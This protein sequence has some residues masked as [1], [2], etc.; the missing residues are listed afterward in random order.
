MNDLITP[1]HPD[2]AIFWTETTLSR[3]PSRNNPAINCVAPKEQAWVSTPDL[4]VDQQNLFYFY[5]LIG[6]LAAAKEALAEI[7]S[8]AESR[9]TASF[10]EALNHNLSKVE[11]FCFVQPL[12]QAGFRLE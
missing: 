2:P 6:R 4:S 11:S 1:S 7:V 8:L 12:K 5:F 9:L 10:D 3:S